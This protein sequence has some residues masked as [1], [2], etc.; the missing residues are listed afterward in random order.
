LEIPSWP[1][2]RP[3]DKPASAESRVVTGVALIGALGL[4]WLVRL[5]A[6]YLGS[7]Q[8]TS[9]SRGA[10]PAAQLTPGP[11]TAPARPAP[12]PDSAGGRSPRTG[13]L[14]LVLAAVLAWGSFY[15]YN[16]LRH[17]F[18]PAHLTASTTNLGTTQPLSL[19]A[20][21]GGGGPTSWQVPASYI[22]RLVVSGPDLGTAEIILPLPRSQCRMMEADLGANCGPGGQV[23]VST[24]VTFAWSS[25]QLVNT[26]DDSKVPSTSINITSSGAGPGSLSVTVLS[27]ANAPPSLC[28]S[29]PFQLQ[30]VTLTVTSASHPPFRYEFPGYDAPGFRSIPCAD[31]LPVF[32]GSPGSG[33]PPELGFEAI[34]SLTLNAWAPTAKL[35]GFAGE[36][37]LDPG[38]ATVL[39]SPTIV[40]LSSGETMP[41]AASVGINLGS[42]SLVVQTKAATSVMTSSGQLVPSYW[43]RNT[44]WLV[45]VL[46]GLVTVL[47]NLFGVSTQVLAD[48]MDRRRGPVRWWRDRK[49]GKQRKIINKPA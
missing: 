40:S 45:P 23:S 8:A 7:R 41:L 10:A 39:G 27:Q 36:V 21:N 11:D 15:G 24:P 44:D 17:T 42:E 13:W 22:G 29:P 26:T 3:R 48:A 49:A 31:G 43:A 16:W 4:V 47:F 30:P 5:I 12:D 28:F 34:R 35:Q 33:F 19:E 32:V 37:D 38:G 20:P 1:G 25:P 9:P 18:P 14:A 2:R 6:T 46:G